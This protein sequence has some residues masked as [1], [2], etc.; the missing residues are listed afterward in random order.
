MRYCVQ[1]G[2]CRSR[3]SRRT[4]SGH[5]DDKRHN[6]SSA[7]LT[8]ANQH[9]VAQLIP[10]ASWLQLRRIANLKQGEMLWQN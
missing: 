1:D 9:S 3:E 4:A 6:R 8:G 10:G 2:V 7:F 5:V